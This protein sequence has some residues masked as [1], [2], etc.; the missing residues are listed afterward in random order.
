MLSVDECLQLPHTYIRYRHTA[1]Y[2]SLISLLVTWILNQI[3]RKT[4]FPNWSFVF[5]VLCIF[6]VLPNDFFLLF[7]FSSFQM[8]LQLLQPDNEF[9]QLG[10]ES[11]LYPL[12][13]CSNL[14]DFKLF[15]EINWKHSAKVQDLFCE[16][17][18][19][20]STCHLHKMSLCDYREWI[21]LQRRL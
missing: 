10:D 1:E 12:T 20:C 7:S 9:I 15:N 6:F 14:V 16:Q 18:S 17:L 4:Q 21:Q 8:S 3:R 5:L 19:V 2:F 13:I 11:E